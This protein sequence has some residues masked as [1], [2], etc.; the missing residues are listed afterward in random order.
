MRKAL[1]ILLLAFFGLPIVS[2]LLALTPRSER[3]LPAC[4]RRN[5]KHHCMMSM[6]EREKLTDSKETRV[7]APDEKCPYAPSIAAFCIHVSPFFP[8]AGKDRFVPPSSH[9]LGMAQT[10]S[11]LRISQVR[12]RQ[13]RGP[14]TPDSLLS[15]SIVVCV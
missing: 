4:C 15:T 11:K 1:S 13:K 10:E 6:A 14:P 8:A 7:A 9:P 5:G 2:P 3:D 12:S